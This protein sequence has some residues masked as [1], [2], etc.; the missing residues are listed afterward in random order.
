MSKVKEATNVASRLSIVGGIIALMSS[1]GQIF[2]SKYD[3]TKLLMRVN[4]NDPYF[5]STEEKVTTDGRKFYVLNVVNPDNVKEKFSLPISGEEDAED[6][7]IWLST[8][9]ADFVANGKTI[10]KGTQKVR[11]Y[12]VVEE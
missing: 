5:V 6:F 9:N 11:C 12:A 4:V 7:E 3:K 10:T 1:L 8:S 2:G